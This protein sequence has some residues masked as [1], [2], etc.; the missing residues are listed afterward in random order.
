VKLVTALKESEMRGYQAWVEAKPDSDFA[1]FMP[2]MA[3]TVRLKK[4]EADALG[5]TNERYDA[6]LDHFEPEM[7][8][9]E[10][11]ALFT[12]LIDGL[13]PLAAAILD[14]A[15]PKPSFLSATYDPEKQS[16]FANALVDRL[17]FDRDAGRLDFSPHP[18]T[19]TIS[20]G[21]IRQTLRTPIS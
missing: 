6:C 10:V 13:Q 12:E 3:E 4:E 21:D 7:T 16:R 15:G 18:F 20:P 19:I 11:E 1:K 5:W 17:G 8:A 9:V 2:F 14:A